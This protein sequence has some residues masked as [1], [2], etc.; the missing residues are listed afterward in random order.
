MKQSKLRGASYAFASVIYSR[1]K[2]ETQV[3]PQDYAEPSST[4]KKLVEESR[5][6]IMICLNIKPTKKPSELPLFHS[7]DQLLNKG[8]TYILGGLK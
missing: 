8:H 6:F 5:M 7:T 2:G 3:C 1:I 4:W